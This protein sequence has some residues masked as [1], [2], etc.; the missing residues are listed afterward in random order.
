V[1]KEHGKVLLQSSEPLALV[2]FSE[3]L[4]LLSPRI[5]C[6]SWMNG[7]IS[8][9]LMELSLRM[10]RF[11][12]KRERGK[13]GKAGPSQEILLFFLLLCSTFPS[14]SATCQSEEIQFPYRCASLGN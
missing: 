12:K 8:Y 5:K 7:Y 13:K 11:E 2:F 14:S 1:R 10:L 4:C 9:V 3:A 6:L